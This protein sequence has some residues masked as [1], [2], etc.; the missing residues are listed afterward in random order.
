MLGWSV[1]ASPARARRCEPWPDGWI[2]DDSVAKVLSNIR[3]TGERVVIH[4]REPGAFVQQLLTRIERRLRAEPGEQ[5]GPVK[6]KAIGCQR[7]QHHRAPTRH[8]GHDD[9]NA[10]T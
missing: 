3:A 8:I 10:V 9:Q 6:S 7:R 1:N 5:Q 4:Q 2:E